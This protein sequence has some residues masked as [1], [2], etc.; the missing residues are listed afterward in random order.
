MILS[1]NSPSSLKQVYTQDTSLQGGVKLPTGG[2][3]AG[4]KALQKAHEPIV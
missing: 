3:F 1:N 4:L 2:K